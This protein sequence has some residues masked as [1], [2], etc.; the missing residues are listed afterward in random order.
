MG[1]LVGFNDTWAR[2]RFGEND[3]EKLA[4]EA[5]TVLTT[6]LHHQGPGAEFTGWLDL[7][8]TTSEE[9]LRRIEEEA[10]RL[11]NNVDTVV[12]CGIGGSYL[13]ARA[14][15][16][17]LTE[18]CTAQTPEILFAGNSLSG[19]QLH[20]LLDHLADRR[21]SLIVVSKS[22]TTLE[23]AIAFH[24]LY[25]ELERRVGATQAPSHVI[26]VTDAERGTLHDLAREKG[27]ATFELPSDVG[28]RYSVLTPAG[29]VP[30]AVKGLDLHAMLQG[31]AEQREQSLHGKPADNASLQYAV[32]RQLLGRQG[33]AVEL[34][35]YFEPS[36]HY[37]AEWWKQLFG[38]S[39]GKEGKGTFPTSAEFSTDLHSLGQFIQQGSRI[40]FETALDIPAPADYTFSSA[41][42]APDGLGYLNG[43]PMSAMN[44]KARLG[45]MLAHHDGG[46]PVLQIM[47]PGVSERAFGAAVYFFE[48]ACAISGSLLRV[49][50]F[51]QPGVEMYKHNMFALLGRPGTEQAAAS[52]QARLA[53]HR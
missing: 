51:D 24:V 1:N 30:F 19:W 34:L 16:T 49:N 27:F 45:T 47:L 25:E 11:C 14:G 26:A 23:T 15:L 21:F 43:Q 17:L 8:V 39:E 18:S 36:A 53:E 46:V 4:G 10:A 40:L 52:I 5:Q 38:E 41:A 2:G 48:A 42:D 13:G 44:A 9:L 6:L 33:N 37:F 50:P 7:P 29:L 20:A 12:L 28:G 35:T 32:M 31:A 22:G 3:R